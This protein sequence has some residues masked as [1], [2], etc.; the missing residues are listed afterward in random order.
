MDVGYCFVGTFRPLD[1]CVVL[2]G[3][4]ILLRSA[5][6]PD[7]YVPREDVEQPIEASLHKL[8]PAKRRYHLVLGPT[9]WLGLGAI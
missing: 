5:G 3:C 1:T 8:D 9:G 4:W 7:V 2:Y 6:L